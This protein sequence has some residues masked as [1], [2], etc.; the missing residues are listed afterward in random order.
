[1]RVKI[2]TIFSAIAALV[3]LFFSIVA[4]MFASY[5]P[6]LLYEG[7]GGIISTVFIIIGMWLFN[8]DS[9]KTIVLYIL[10]AIF[11]LFYMQIDGGVDGI[12]IA[13]LLITSIIIVYFERGK[14]KII[15][16]SNTNTFNNNQ[17]NTNQKPTPIKKDKKLWIIPIVFILIMI[18]I[19]ITISDINDYQ[20]FVDNNNLNVSGTS[21]EYIGNNAYE[22]N[23]YVVPLRNYNYLEMQV[24]FYDAQGL[25]IPTQNTLIWNMNDPIINQGI[26]VS[27]FET[28]NSTQ[29]PVKAEVYFFDQPLSNDISQAVYHFTYT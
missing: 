13:I 11:N 4:F 18:P 8:Q 26:K 29:T 14:S 16:K 12:I 2:N 19:G 15:T 25:A 10:I 21:I 28:L 3:T 20:T 22:I 17:Q 1:M 5:D 9:N 7:L 24:I 6:I 27:G 23:S